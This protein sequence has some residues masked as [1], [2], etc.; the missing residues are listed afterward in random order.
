M[1]KKNCFENKFLGESIYFS[2]I[3]NQT[4]RQN[5]PEKFWTIILA[6]PSGNSVLYQIHAQRCILLIYG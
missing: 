3:N 1:L 5:M 6:I 2:Q 4:A